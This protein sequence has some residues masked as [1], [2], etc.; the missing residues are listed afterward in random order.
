MVEAKEAFK[1]LME[2]NNLDDKLK[3][4]LTQEA[5]EDPAS[6]QD[7]EELDSRIATLRDYGIDCQTTEENLSLVRDQCFQVYEGIYELE[8][9]Y[10]VPEKD[11]SDSTRGK[12]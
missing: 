9:S 2:L 1:R 5:F 7:A 12:T 3:K 4:V 10:K 8:N 6:I 11:I